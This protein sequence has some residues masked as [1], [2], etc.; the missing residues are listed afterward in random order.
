VERYR[1]TLHTRY[2]CQCA[3]VDHSVTR[4]N[5]HDLC[6][7]ISVLVILLILSIL[8]YGNSL[9]YHQMCSNDTSNYSIDD[10]LNKAMQYKSVG[11]SYY[12]AGEYL[13][14][15]AQYGKIF[16][17]VNCLD[18]PTELTSMNLSEDDNQHINP[19]ASQRAIAHSI[20]ISANLNL[21]ISYLK[22]DEIKKSLHYAEEALVLDPNNAKARFRRAQCLL[23]LGQYENALEDLKE[24][25]KVYPNDKEIKNEINNANKKLQQQKQK[26]RETF[27]KMFD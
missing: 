12:A 25:I 4:S 24:A 26:Q 14:A 15:I 27:A 21:S 1:E 18:I 23:R 13:S 9:F 5:I 6:S 7:I 22:L 10:Y 3:T 17:W 16:L 11:N 2:C 8:F 19:T 20:R